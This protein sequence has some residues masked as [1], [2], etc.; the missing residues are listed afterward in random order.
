M[1]EREKETV[2]RE[3][4]MID[5]KKVLRDNWVPA[6]NHPNFTNQSLRV[7]LKKNSV[8]PDKFRSVIWTYLLNL[9]KNALSY[10]N[11]IK[12]GIHK[13]YENIE[14]IFPLKNT[15]LTKKLGRVLSS[16]AHY[17]PIFADKQIVPFIS[18]PFIKLFSTDECLSFE[19]IITF[20][21]HWGQHMFENYPQP[22]TTMLDLV[23][24]LL[25]RQSQY[26]I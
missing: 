25:R 13:E 6:A 15:Q 21:L 4:V 12:K 2:E 14:E 22:S 16:L 5:E 1:N 9:P 20:F 8:F 24:R 11:Y 3:V 23:L 19:F 17:S 18:F 26:S 7:F 10:D